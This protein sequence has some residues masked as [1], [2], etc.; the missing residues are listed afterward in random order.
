[1]KKT[2]IWIGQ[3]ALVAS[4]NTDYKFDGWIKL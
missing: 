4:I 1:M 3:K 2:M